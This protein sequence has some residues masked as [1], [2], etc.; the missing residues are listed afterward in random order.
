MSEDRTRLSNLHK[1]FPRVF[2]KERKD[3]DMFE[4]AEGWTELLTL[5]AARIN[6][7]LKADPSATMQILQIKEKFGELRFYYR[8]SD[9][10]EATQAA[11]RE[12]VD[13]AREASAFVCEACGQPGILQT[14]KSGWIRVRCLDCMVS[15]RFNG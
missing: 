1:Q 4:H 5:L 3:Q 13:A 11:V 2:G 12:A 6:T 7:I 8:L 10:S 15:E 14:S 9:A